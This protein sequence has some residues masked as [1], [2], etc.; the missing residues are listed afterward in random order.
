[1][2]EVAD[3]FTA[4]FDAEIVEAWIADDPDPQTATTLSSILAAA[5]T[6][7]EAA[8]ADLEDR[9]AGPLEFGTA[10]LR[11]EIAA[12]PNRMNRA[13]VIRAAAG[14]SR[15]LLNTVGEGFTVVIG[16]DARYKSSDFAADTAAVVTA[17]GG[18]AIQLPDQLPTPLLAFALSHLKAD[19]GVMVTASHNPPA[20]NGY[21]VYLG[22]RPL[23]AI[24]SD[25]GAAE[26]GAGAQIVSP[27]DALI[28]EQIA[29]VSS[30]ASV[31]RAE[32]AW[33]HL[34]ESIVETYLARIDALDV[35]SNADLTI[36]HTSLHG[37]GASVAEAAL[38][39]TGFSNVHPVPS[40]QTPEPDFPTVAF[41][42]PEEAGALDES[43]ALAKEVNADLI[44][45]NDPDADRFSAAIPDVS[46]AAGY[47]QLSGDEVGLLLGEDI[48][49]RMAQGAHHSKRQVAADAVGVEG[50]AGGA[51][52]AGAGEAS[53]SASPVFANS[54]VSSRGLAAAAESHG[55]TAKNTL[56]G[57]KWISRVPDLVFGYE[58]ALGYCVDPTA[59]RDKDGIS[60]AVTFAALA[61][62]LKESGS[63]I[64]TEL[65]RIR[66]R[67]G[68]FATAPLSFRFDDVSLI[69][70]AMAKLRENPPTTLAGSPVAEVH[71]LSLGYDGLPPTDGILLL[72]EAN[73]R[74]IV[75]PSGTE[76]KLKCYLE[77]VA[78]P[79]ELEASAEADTRAAASAGVRVSADSASSSLKPALTE[80][81]ASINTEL[82][83]FFGL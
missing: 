50:S 77:V 82:K 16:C 22:Q 63:S 17:A 44:I 4:G 71:D 67:D 21:K 36:V 20:D 80:R 48:A 54:I 75:R 3:R 1:M 29:A 69:A 57:F 18:T 45:A 41:P 78:D 52:P 66:N 79:S 30:V 11:G 65:D 73:S 58:E 32:S 25:P 19:A 55:F 81:L 38:A 60:A 23:L 40:Q 64:E 53:D 46:L 7:D 31:P 28:A 70:A 39:R 27:A 2:T 51:G 33:E 83:T 72:S 8:L 74:V 26:A 68:Y 37:V 42:N 34:D 59:V 43:Y 62:R 14:L 35:R 61:S 15:F 10:G 9:F 6:G 56:T 49:T 13:V 76:P 24:E 47:R 12:G 5:K